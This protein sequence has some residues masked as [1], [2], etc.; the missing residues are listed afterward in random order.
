MIFGHLETS[1]R[2]TLFQ[3]NEKSS[4]HIVC[5]CWLN[6]VWIVIKQNHWYV[7]KLRC[8]ESCG[9]H[10]PWY[11]SQGKALSFCICSCY[12]LK[13]SCKFHSVNMTYSASLA[14]CPR[15]IVEPFFSTLHMMTSLHWWN[16]LGCEEISTHHGSSL[17]V[18]GSNHYIDVIM[19]A[20][21]SQITILT[22]VYSTVYSG[23]DKKN[24][25][26]PRHWLLRGEFTGR[27]WILLTKGQYCGKCFHLITSSW[28]NRAHLQF[29]SYSGRQHLHS[30]PKYILTAIP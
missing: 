15:I 16:A 20:I 29:I 23:A 7:F 27:R 5:N 1:L 25:K 11:I 17:V 6:A 10:C 4:Q 22:I 9:A 18:Y 12:L 30:I 13:L 2:A 24:I 8:K 26:A 14:H 19:S 3:T 21:A 28:R